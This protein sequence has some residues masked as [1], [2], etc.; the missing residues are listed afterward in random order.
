MANGNHTHSWAIWLGISFHMVW[1][2]LILIAGPRNSIQ[3]EW[4][5]DHGGA[6]LWATL[7]VTTALLAAYGM[8]WKPRSFWLPLSLVPQ[9][10]LLTLGALALVTV[11]INGATLFGKPI[12]SV[13]ILQATTAEI[14]AAVFHNIAA[15]DYHWRGFWKRG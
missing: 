9:Q 3:M 4:V 10:A 5:A 7:M 11:A 8:I 15:I 6:Y 13:F 2:G 12:D 14:L 1:G